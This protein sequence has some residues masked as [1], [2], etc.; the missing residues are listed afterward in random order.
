MIIGSSVAKLHEMKRA[1][2][3][4]GDFRDCSLQA[5]PVVAVSLIRPFGPPSPTV[6]EKEVASAR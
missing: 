6:W 5:M 1:G 2:W 4:S 3:G